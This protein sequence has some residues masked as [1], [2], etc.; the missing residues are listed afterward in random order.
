MM[1]DDNYDDDYHHCHNNDD[2][3]D[4]PDGGDD[5]DDND[6][7][8]DD[9]DYDAADGDDDSGVDEKDETNLFWKLPYIKILTSQTKEP[10]DLLP[11]KQRPHRSSPISLSRAPQKSI[12]QPHRELLN[13][14][15]AKCPAPLA[16]QSLIR[17][18]PG[19]TLGHNTHRD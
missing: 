1:T 19:I 15:T 4:N 16:L 10:A 5:E 6:D 7:H 14:G 11:P 13:P 9:N 17:A 3:D 18:G 8:D 12:L 2:S